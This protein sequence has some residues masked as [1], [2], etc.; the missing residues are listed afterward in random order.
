MVKP[1]SPVKK[2]FRWSARVQIVYKHELNFDW[3]QTTMEKDEL[4]SLVDASIAC[5]TKYT[6]DVLS[7]VPLFG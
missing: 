6:N 1:G 7:P 3:L 4:I 2:A 5:N